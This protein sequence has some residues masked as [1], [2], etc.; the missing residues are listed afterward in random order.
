MLLELLR[1]L[2]VLD[3]HELLL[4]LLALTGQISLHR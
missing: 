1:L 3:S 4:Q 2:W